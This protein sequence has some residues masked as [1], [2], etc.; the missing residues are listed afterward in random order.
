ML[1]KEVGEGER[2]QNF[3]LEI[4]KKYLNNWVKEKKITTG[5]KR[6]FKGKIVT[7]RK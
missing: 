6:F 1:G 5:I 3:M 7:R 2:E 4:E